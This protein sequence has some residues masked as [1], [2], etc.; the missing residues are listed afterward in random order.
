MTISKYT[1]SIRRYYLHICVHTYI[2]IYT[3]CVCSGV[4]ALICILFIHVYVIKY[5]YLAG[6]QNIVE[7]YIYISLY[8]DVRTYLQICAV[9]TMTLCMEE[10]T[11]VVVSIYV[12]RL[13]QDMVCIRM[14]I[15]MYIICIYV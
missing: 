8:F 11:S 3:H 2:R 10:C 9:Y 7:V 15:H 12:Y 4:H 13:V 1:Q 5:L 14:Y 6:V